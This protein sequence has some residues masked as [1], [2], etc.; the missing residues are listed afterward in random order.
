MRRSALGFDGARHH[1]ATALIGCTADGHLFA[2]KVWERPEGLRQWDVPASEVDAA[3]YAAMERWRVRRAYFDPP[4]WQSEID[5]WGREFGAAVQPWPTN[6]NAP[7]A[8]ACERFRT[9]AQGG[10]LSHDMDPTLRRHH[11]AAAVEQTRHG[12]VL[13]RRQKGGPDHIDAAVA[14][15]LAYEARADAAA[16][17]EF[18]RRYRVMSF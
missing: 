15:V 18:G 9:D 3:V 2:I 4:L 12:P 11:L 17:G 14:S 8:A 6:R 16:A 1:D 5:A 13:V 10:A 7:M